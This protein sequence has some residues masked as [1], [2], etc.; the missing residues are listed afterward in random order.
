M[1]GKDPAKPHEFDESF[2]GFARHFERS[3]SEV[4]S[5]GKRT[6]PSMKQR[7]EKKSQITSEETSMSKE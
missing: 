2:A 6:Q 3:E 4:A 7:L 1:E 5:M